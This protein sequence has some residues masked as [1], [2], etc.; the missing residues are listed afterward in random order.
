MLFN[1]QCST[2]T[3]DQFGWSEVVNSTIHLEI[4]YASLSCILCD[5][6]FLQYTE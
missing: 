1:H 2:S 6:V 4:T 3:R 5:D